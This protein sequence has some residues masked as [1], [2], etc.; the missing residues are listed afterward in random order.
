VLAGLGSSARALRV[1]PLE[2]LRDPT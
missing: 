2:V 1:N